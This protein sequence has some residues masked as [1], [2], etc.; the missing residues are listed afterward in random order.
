MLIRRATKYQYVSVERVLEQIQTGYWIL[1]CGLIPNVPVSLYN[2]I[3]VEE[4][5]YFR[6]LH[7]A[8]SGNVAGG[9]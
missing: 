1:R 7:N 9:Q 4:L 6:R 8:V 3:K 5:A 2:I